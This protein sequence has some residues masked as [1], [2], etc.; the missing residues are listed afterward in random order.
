[1]LHQVADGEVGGVALRAVAEQTLGDLFPSAGAHL[2]CFAS[3][4]R[5]V[6]A[7]IFLSR[8]LQILYTLRKM[9]VPEPPSD[10]QCTVGVPTELAKLK[11]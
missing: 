9:L 11:W 2:E 8:R 1:M 4:G 10:A 6:E 3:P 5:C 7:A